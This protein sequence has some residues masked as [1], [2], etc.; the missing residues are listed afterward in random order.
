MINERNRLRHAVRT[1]S[2]PVTV[3]LALKLVPVWLSAAVLAV[4]ALALLALANTLY[5]RRADPHLRLI[6]MA[7]AFR[8]TGTDSIVAAT[9][10]A[11]TR[12]L[13]RTRNWSHLPRHRRVA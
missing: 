13:D 10:P 3:V 9:L 8:P 2:A 1:V 12:H 5:C 11:P 4:A 7:T 6:A